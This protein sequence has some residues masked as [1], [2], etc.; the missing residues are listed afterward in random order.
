MMPSADYDALHFGPCVHCGHLE[1]E[2]GERGE[3]LRAGC[4]GNRYGCCMV[5]HDPR[6][7][8]PEESEQ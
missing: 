5:E 3:C 2:H 7:L 8:P 4:Y 6:V 1:D